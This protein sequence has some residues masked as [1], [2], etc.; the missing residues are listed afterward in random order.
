MA[1][2][3]YD[4]FFREEYPRLVTVG[5]ALC[6][7]RDVARDLAQE[8]LLR[9]YRAWTSVGSMAHPGAWCRRVLVNL[10]VDRGRRRGREERALARIGVAAPVTDLP[11][12]AG[13]TAAFWAAVRALPDRQRAAV[14]L[15]Y[16]EDQS[17]DGIAEILDIAAGTVKATLHRARQT[18]AATLSSWKEQS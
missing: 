6:G 4:A 9:A 12:G 1:A 5:T 3:D 15:H 17:V 14:V 10:T 16:V 7:D 13:D 11:P 8:C 18:L 2:P